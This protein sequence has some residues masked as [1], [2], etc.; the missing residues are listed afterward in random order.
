MTLP[1]IE[2][3]LMRRRDVIL[4]GAAALLALG[5]ARVTPAR[6]G[7]IMSWSAPVLT[8][9]QTIDIETDLHSTGVTQLKPDSD[10]IIRIGTQSHGAIVRSTVRLRG[11]RNIV[12]VG[13]FIKRAPNTPAS[14]PP[15]YERSPYPNELFSIREHTGV[16]YVEGLLLDCDN[17]YGV[18]AMELGSKP[19]APPPNY[20]LRHVLVRGVT[21]KFQG[22]HAD[23]LQLTQPTG[24]IW[25]GH[26]TVYS[27]YQALNIQPSVAIG[28]CW[29][30][31]CNTRYP[32]PNV[33]SGEANGFAF[34]LDGP[35]NRFHSPVKYRL[36]NVYV[37]ART[38]KAWNEGTVA[39]PASSMIGNR[40]VPGHPNSVQFPYPALNCTG[41]VT[42]GIPPAGDFC[43]AS[44]IVD[45]S[46][47]VIYK[48]DNRDAP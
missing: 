6:A 46:G 26:M 13:G 43:T 37:Q 23:G 48:G 35:E 19:P 15:N 31:S 42:E 3:R 18:D 29:L 39:P 38:Y 33:N 8:N 40:P 20:V 11:G 1:Q 14:L 21:G 7:E 30:S 47:S 12:L 44:Q 34:W 24:Q 28:L 32:N 4:Q 2:R 36:D 27:A 5:P 45:A 25:I 22:E 41:F 10:Y 17:N 9:P 16:A